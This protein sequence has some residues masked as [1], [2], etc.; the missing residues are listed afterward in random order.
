L[1]ASNTAGQNDTA[2]ANVL[3]DMGHGDTLYIPS[4]ATPYLFSTF[5]PTKTIHI[6]GGSPGHVRNQRPF[7]YANWTD[8]TAISSGLVAGTVLRSTATTGS[9]IF[10]D[11]NGDLNH[12]SLEDII[13]I[14]PGTG[15][16]IGLT[17]GAQASAIGF[18]VRTRLRNVTVANF[19][20]GIDSTCENATWDG[21]YIVGCS[22]GLS[23]HY[24]FNG[25]TINGLN[26]EITSVAAVSMVA[27]DGNRFNG[28][29]IQGNTGKGIYMAGCWAN[30]FESIYFENTA[31]TGP[32]TDVQLSTDVG[33]TGL[34][35]SDNT[36]N[37]FWATHA[38]A[39]P[40]FVIDQGSVRNT[41]S[42]SG[43]HAAVAYNVTMSGAYNVF[44]MNLSG[45][46]T[47]SGS[48]RNNAY[49][50]NNFSSGTFLPMIPV[51]GSATMLADD[52]L[53][54]IT[55]STTVTVTL[56]DPT[57]VRKGKVL[58]VKNATATTT[59]T[60]TSAGASKTI[61]GAASV[62]MA[63][64]QARSFVSDGTQW[65]TV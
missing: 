58:R 33:A 19:A 8:G 6:K 5:S 10:L 41:F 43:P 15:T 38:S 50:D 11:M 61:D 56:P 37:G 53:W 47:E 23:T 44:N 39:S 48:A 54:V 26:V 18:P 51:T 46:I 57:V 22:T 42:G 29:V 40:R 55:T 14:G 64:W 35:C 59:H 16:S 21:I 31:A 49:R 62:A 24:P 30:S 13:L 17:V 60:V 65:L 34:A 27:S 7:G 25:N 1:S 9:A 36:F 63:A 45:T 12:S 3:T 20:T 52:N 4:A 28:G 2:L 32:Q